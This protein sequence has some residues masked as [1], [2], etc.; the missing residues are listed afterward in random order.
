MNYE[1]LPV[2][3]IIQFPSKKPINGRSNRDQVLG[4]LIPKMLGVL[5]DEG[6]ARGHVNEPGFPPEIYAEL[7]PGTGGNLAIG[8]YFLNTAGFGLHAYVGMGEDQ[9]K[10]FSCHLGDRTVTDGT[11]WHYLNGR[12]AILSWK[13]GRWENR[14]MEASSDERSIAH[15]LTAGLARTKI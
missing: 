9:T 2:T 7:G 15:V 12:C 4:E 14:L 11:G 1:A 8:G 6:V 13:R 10:V 3:K 5:W